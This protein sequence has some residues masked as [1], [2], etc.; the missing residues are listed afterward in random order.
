MPTKK[1]FKSLLKSLKQSANSVG[2]SNSSSYANT[3][4]QSWA[5]T[6][7]NTLPLPPGSLTWTNNPWQF[8]PQAQVGSGYALSGVAGLSNWPYDT[9][10]PNKYWPWTEYEIEAESERDLVLDFKSRHPDFDT[11]QDE[12]NLILARK[13][14]L[15]NTTLFITLIYEL[16]KDIKKLLDNYTDPDKIEEILDGKTEETGG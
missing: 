14:G 13:P 1:S 11:L 5:S 2:I 3:T 6:S 10:T 8:Q 9:L 4:A 16:A 12:V 15:K 7:N